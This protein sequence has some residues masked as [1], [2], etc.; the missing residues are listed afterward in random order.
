MVELPEPI[1]LLSFNDS[2]G[3][4][5]RED[6]PGLWSDERLVRE[7]KRS[8][9]DELFS[10]L[11]GRYKDRTF[12]LAVSVLGPSFEQEA[13]EVVQDVFLTVYR[14]LGHFRFESGF[15]SWLYRIAYNR[16][17]DIRRKPRI[18][19]QHS[20]ESKL[21]AYS[22]HEENPLNLAAISERRTNL[23]RCIKELS[24]PYRTVVYLHYW[25]DCSISEISEQLG[26]KPS[27]VKSQLFRAR[28]QL[29]RIVK[30]SVSNV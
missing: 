9:N 1:R 30:G 12:R 29:A 17:I 14:R 4:A 20:D 27:T 15:G 16:A 19:H 10:I 25:M 3:L 28:K 7:F 21:R 6:S 26:A 5:E 22:T 13:E 24:E 8:R 18:R 11:V 23:L 2:L